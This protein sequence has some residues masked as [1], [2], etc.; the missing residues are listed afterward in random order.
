MARISRISRAPTS[1]NV[2]LGQI[3]GYIMN[4]LPGID[5]RVYVVDVALGILA[6][7]PE[8]CEILSGGNFCGR[9][10]SAIHLQF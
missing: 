3:V 5:K 10:S 4:N 2:L 9:R 7:V 1:S 6:F 8:I